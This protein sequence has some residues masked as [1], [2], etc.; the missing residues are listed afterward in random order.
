[1][2][3]IAKEKEIGKKSLG[4]R[5]QTEKDNNEMG[6]MMDLY[7]ELQKIPQDEKT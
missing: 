7:Y 3:T 6:N 5:E 2:E 4:V 1:M